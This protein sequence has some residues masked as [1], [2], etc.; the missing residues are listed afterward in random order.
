[1]NE[2]IK[3]RPS[4]TTNFAA[5]PANAWDTLPAELARQGIEVA[6]RYNAVQVLHEIG[7][8]ALLGFLDE[9][10]DIDYSGPCYVVEA[11]ADAG[12]MHRLACAMYEPEAT[13]AGPEPTPFDRADAMFH[14]FEQID[15]ELNWALKD[16]N[17]RTEEMARQDL[18]ALWPDIIDVMDEGI[19]FCRENDDYVEQTGLE[20]IR[21]WIVATMQHHFPTLV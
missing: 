17:R 13:E 21:Q 3:I 10:N 20:D 4:R 6:R 12:D 7:S 16:G 9:L 11:Y 18:L 14:E 1:M 19:A 15:R 2:F 8:N 5:I